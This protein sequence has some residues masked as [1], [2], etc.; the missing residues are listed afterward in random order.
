MIFKR[1]ASCELN[2]LEGMFNDAEIKNAIFRIGSLKAPGSDGLQPIFFQSQW[3]IIGPSVFDLVKKI[4]AQPVLIKDINGTLVVLIPKVQ[5]R[6][7]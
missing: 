6:N 2:V 1:I 4:H 7:S 3:E 5:Q